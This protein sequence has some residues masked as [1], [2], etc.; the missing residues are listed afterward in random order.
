[1]KIKFPKPIRAALIDMDGVLYDSMPRHARAWHKMMSEAGVNTTVD[2][3]FLYEGMTGPA[4]IDLIMMRERGCHVDPQE[5][6]R[7]YARKAEYFVE[8]G[9]PPIMPGA[10]D[11]LNALR[12][13]GV[14][15]V[16]VTGS[17]QHTILDRISTDYPNVFS[18]RV[19]ALDVTH[20]K[21]H[22]E[23]Y[24]K[25]LAHAGTPLEQTIVIENAPLGVRAGKAAGLF[26]VAVTTGPIE[27]QAF[28]DEGADMIFS[29]MPEFAKFLIDEL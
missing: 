2:E 13:A 5:A 10:A 9:E 15:C 8:Q 29:S 7:L 1:M 26:T 24:L 19:T 21:P 28:E 17:A 23:P 12:D 3:F 22:P 6:K 14:K 18:E 16:L 27:R 11:M 25:G 20:G 4:T